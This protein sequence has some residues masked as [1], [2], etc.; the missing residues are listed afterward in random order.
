MYAIR[1]YYAVKLAAVIDLAEDESEEGS[2]GLTD[3]ELMYISEGVND[4][5][6]ELSDDLIM[7][8]MKTAVSR[9]L[10]G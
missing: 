10:M 9:G 8:I 1:S 7:N 6:L 4:Y 2:P 5:A 3:D